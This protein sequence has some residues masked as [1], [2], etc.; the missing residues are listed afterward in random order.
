MKESHTNEVSS[1]AIRPKINEPR[2]TGAIGKGRCPAREPPGMWDPG[3][4]QSAIGPTRTDASKRRS[5]AT[6]LVRTLTVDVDEVHDEL[7]G[8][9]V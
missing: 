1:E 8:R 5:T 6:T 2:A 4:C 3:Y 9:V 7:G